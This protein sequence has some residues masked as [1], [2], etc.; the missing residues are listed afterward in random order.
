MEG[1]R[2]GD[3][4]PSGFSV[5]SSRKAK[6]EDGKVAVGKARPTAAGAKKDD[7]GAGASR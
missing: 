2:G 1:G 3:R 6:A 5:R 4:R 7:S